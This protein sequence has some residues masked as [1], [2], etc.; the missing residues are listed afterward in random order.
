MARQFLR[1][2]YHNVVISHQN[3]LESI[4]VLTHPTFSFPLTIKNTVNAIDDL[5]STFR[6]ISPKDETILVFHALLQKYACTSNAIFDAYLTA[7]ALTN[8]V[9]VIATDNERHFRI[10]EEITIYN[11]FTRS[12]H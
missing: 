2:E 3:I 4:R 5:A 11:P 7:T 10:F 9:S 12:L 8:G 6:V 1:K